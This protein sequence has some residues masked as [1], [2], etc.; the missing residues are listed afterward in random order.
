[1]LA[2]LLMDEVRRFGEGFFLNHPYF[3]IS[4]GGA[5]FAP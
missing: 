1:M 5:F 2:G 3:V 4:T